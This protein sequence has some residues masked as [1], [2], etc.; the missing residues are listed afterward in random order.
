MDNPLLTVLLKQVRDTRKAYMTGMPGV[1]V[2]DMQEAAMR[3]LR[4]RHTVL[5][6]QGKRSKPP[7]K[8]AVA[9]FLR[10]L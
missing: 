2:E 1:T 9:G 8:Q 4:M 10:A 3:Y 6:A 7:T 5:K